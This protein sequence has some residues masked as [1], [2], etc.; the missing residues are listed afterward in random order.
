MG[1]FDFFKQENEQE[2]KRYSKLH[3]EL[4]TEYPD[5]SEENLVIT[6][7]IA[8]LLARVA[9][10]DF[11]LDEKELEQIRI[12]LHDWKITEKVDSDILADMAIKHIKE[13]AGLENLLYVLP[14]REILNADQ[15]HK[16]LE[17]L[18]LI[19]ASDGVVE[20]VESEEIRTICK[21][22]ELPNQN[23]L[24]ARASV[25]KYLKSLNC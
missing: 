1:I 8:G 25:A 13:M 20:A 23:F 6:G 11:H 22:L 4:R 14:L 7:C 9:Y 2:A 12:L 21:G 3:E 5:L 10:V 19:A 17:S 15:K 18:F 24:V 16:V